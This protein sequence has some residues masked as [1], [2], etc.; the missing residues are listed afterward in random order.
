MTVV[1]ACNLPDGVI[2]GTDSAVTLDSSSARQ[3]LVHKEKLFALKNKPIG[4]AAYGITGIGP[5][6][7]RS[8]INEFTVTDPN[9]VM[10]ESCEISRVVES[11]RSFFQQIYKR[12][13][14]E[15]PGPFLGLAVA[16]FSPNAYHG[17]IWQIHLPEH[18]K[19][20]SAVCVHGQG[21]FG[22]TWHG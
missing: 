10:T 15:K 6:T 14:G 1:V 3:V 5:R 8:Y 7:I 16:G 22:T 13:F 11:L 18:S 17:E 2:L 12:N 4:V 19:P 21:S 20:D 9:G